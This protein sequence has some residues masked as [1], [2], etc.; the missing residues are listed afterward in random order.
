MTMP[1]VAA[2]DLLR[3]RLDE[4]DPRREGLRV[5]NPVQEQDSRLRTCLL[6]SLLRVARQNR[7][8]QV[9]RIAVFEVCRVFV[10]RPAE[11]LPEEPLQLAALVT[12]GRERHLWDP[13]EPPPLY[14]EAR[15]IAER[16]FSGLGYEACLRRGGNV[17]Y[18]HPGAQ[19]EIAVSDRPI[20]SVGELHPEV[21]RAFELDVPAA[22]VEVDLGALA[23]APAPSVRFREPSREPAIRRDLAVLIDRAQSAGELV[24]EIRKRAGADLVS[25]EI[26]DRYEGSGV[27]RGKTSVAFR[28]V[29]QRAD[30]TLV[31]T[32]VNQAMDLVVRALSERFG[33]ELR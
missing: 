21:L 19:A 8:R 24:E 27:P 26:F 6:P 7:A 15:G 22:F 16:L 9:D 33:A 29:F 11:P 4:A 2:E 28:L 1:F 18:L 23:A 10:P 20:G 3:L 25:V 12:R 17:A 14:F 13:P 5:L 32:E 31:D 30:R